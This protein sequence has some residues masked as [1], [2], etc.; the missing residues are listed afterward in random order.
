[1]RWRIF[2]VITLVLPEPGPARINCMP[3][4]VMALC[5]EGDR[6]MDVFPPAAGIQAAI[7]R[8]GGPGEKNL[9]GD[10]TIS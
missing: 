6:G 9:I 1:M 2:S 5:R 8:P 4:S 7:A 10:P 3:V